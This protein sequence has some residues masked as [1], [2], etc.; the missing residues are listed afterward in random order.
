MSF[1]YVVNPQHVFTLK[2]S[3]RYL[4]S[5]F[6]DMHGDF[7]FKH[8]CP[9]L[10]SFQSRPRIGRKHDP[11]FHSFARGQLLSS[12]SSA[13]SYLNLPK[14]LF[15][16]LQDNFQYKNLSSSCG[17]H[18]QGLIPTN[19]STWCLKT[20][21]ASSRLFLRNASTRHYRCF[22]IVTIKFPKSRVLVFTNIARFSKRKP[23][24]AR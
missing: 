24:L 19:T 11:S 14:L 3:L 5:Y 15:P 4:P 22:S 1:R 17:S 10:A 23:I 6:N 21:P 9:Q 8:H 16:T 18:C 7:G 20:C 12:R 2:W 13:P